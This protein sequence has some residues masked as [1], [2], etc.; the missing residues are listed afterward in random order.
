MEFRRVEIKKVY[1]HVERV[2]API[3]VKA[4]F[5]AL[6]QN[7][8]T[9]VLRTRSIGTPLQECSVT[10]IG[11]ESATIF[12]RRP[13]KL[14]VEARYDDVELVE[15]CCDREIVAEEDDDGGR[16]ARII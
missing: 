12:S 5:E 16:W 11:D 10:S 1:R 8:L 4:I 13:M 15:V 3:D 2:T 7:S 9:F 6:L 14:T